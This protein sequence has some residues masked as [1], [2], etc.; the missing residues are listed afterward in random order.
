MKNMEN[1]KDFITGPHPETRRRSPK[2][3]ALGRKNLGSRVEQ[4]R[5]RQAV[6]PPPFAPP[7]PSSSFGQIPF[8]RRGRKT[9]T[10]SR[11]V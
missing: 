8:S 1:V 6:P 4:L 5:A 9:Q 2:N 11:K 10:R 7:W 3:L